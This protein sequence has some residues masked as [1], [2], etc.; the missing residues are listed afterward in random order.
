MA[1]FG[2]KLKQFLTGDYAP[3]T[4]KNRKPSFRLHREVGQLF[5]RPTVWLDDFVTA[6]MAHGAWRELHIEGDVLGHQR[7]L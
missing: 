5:L 1:G 6:G 3:A 2:Y 7:F 4:M